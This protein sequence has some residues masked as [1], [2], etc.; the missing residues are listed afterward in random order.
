MLR[1]TPYLQR[2]ISCLQRV[3]TS[4][5]SELT[6]VEFR[7]LMIVGSGVLLGGAYGAFTAEPGSECFQTGKWSM[8]GFVATACFPESVILG[9]PLVMMIEGSRWRNGTTGKEQIRI[10]LPVTYAEHKGK[11]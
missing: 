10:K 4:A 2:T 3:S 5:R 7:R 8:A 9:I 11:D 1:I 6:P